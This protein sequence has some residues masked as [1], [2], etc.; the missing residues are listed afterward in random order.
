MS[1]TTLSSL[2]VYY[3]TFNGYMYYIMICVY[4]QYLNLKSIIS[5]LIRAGYLRATMPVP[6]FIVYKVYGYRSNELIDREDITAKY[7]DGHPVAPSEKFPRLEYRCMWKN[8]KYKINSMKYFCTKDEDVV[9]IHL[10]TDAVVIDPCLSCF[11]RRKT[12]TFIVDA[13]LCGEDGSA[14]NVY[15]RLHKFVGPNQDFFNQ[16]FIVKWLLK[17]EIESGLYSH[18]SVV[19][20]DGKCIKYMMSECI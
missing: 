18:L 19:Y 11:S 17:N 7:L 9:P 4:L 13:C 1:S 12:T 20:S 15:K 10:P 16:P 8:K 2:S 14:S 6:P 3:C 5:R